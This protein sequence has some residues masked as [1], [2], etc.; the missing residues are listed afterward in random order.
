MINLIFDG[1]YIMH[2]S[3]YVYPRQSRGPML[4]TEEDRRAFVRKVVMDMA[5][6]IRKF[7]VVGKVIVTWDDYSWRKMVE[8]EENEGYKSNRVK[9]E[10]K[11]DWT[12]FGNIQ[13]DLTEILEKYNFIISKI[14]HAEGDDLM[15]LWSHELTERGEDIGI[16]SGDR[17]ITQ[18]VHR[19]DP[20]FCFVYD[21]KSTKRMFFANK[22]LRDHLAGENGEVSLFDMSFMS[23]SNDEVLELIADAQYN[24]VDPVDVVWGKTL[25]GDGGDGVPPVWSWKKPHGDKIATF[26]VT[27]KKA[28]LIKQDIIAKYGSFELDG[29]EQ[30]ADVVVA[31]IKKYH[32]EIADFGLVEERIKR[33]LILVWLDHNVIPQQ[34]Q[35]DFKKHFEIYKDF[36]Q[37]N[38]PAFNHHSLLEGT[39]Y[40]GTASVQSDFFAKANKATKQ[41]VKGN[42]LF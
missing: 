35:D 20:N 18:C 42:K 8:I 7:K 39:K 26:S 40:E 24:E 5:F 1:N 36:G 31:G 2:R 25:A 34:V 27:Q 6:A 3:M 17:D 32:K 23:N 38:P 11:V 12:E 14:K 16:I 33:N 22:G 28:L 15:F 37:P 4:N 29:C 9:D 13:D 21:P 10:S 41:T 19:N 30:Y